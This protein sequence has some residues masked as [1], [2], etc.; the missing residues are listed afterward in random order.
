[1]VSS[2][3]RQH[4]RREEP[5]ALATRR[6]REVHGETV[7]ALRDDLAQELRSQYNIGYTPTNSKRDGTYRKVEVKI[8]G[9]DYRV[10]ARAGYYAPSTRDRAGGQE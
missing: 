4:H 5:R 8:K 9:G 7:G 2:E 6:V 3:V 10:Q 1:M